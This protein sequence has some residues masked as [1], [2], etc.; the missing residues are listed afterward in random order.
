MTS[1]GMEGGALT[2]VRSGIRVGVAD[3]P[4]VE[5]GAGVKVEVEVGSGV[6]VAVGVA[7]AS[8]RSELNVLHPNA[9]NPRIKKNIRKKVAPRGRRGGGM[10][11][12][13]LTKSRK[14]VSILNG[15]THTLS[16][17]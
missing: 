3:G 13:G 10:E 17:M 1:K 15:T 7:V 8:K 14:G 12:P 2:N 16:Y 9:P 4:E 6:R 11:R 5:V